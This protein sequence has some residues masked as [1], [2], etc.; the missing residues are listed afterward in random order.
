MNIF[1]LSQSQLIC[2][3]RVNELRMLYPG[4]SVRIQSQL[5][6]HVLYKPSIIVLFNITVSYQLIK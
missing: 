1:V 2:N 6:T 3:T 4:R 5:Y